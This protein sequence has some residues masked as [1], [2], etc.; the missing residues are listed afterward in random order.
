MTWFRYLN[1]L[2]FFFIAVF[3]IAYVLYVWRIYRIAKVLNTSFKRIIAKLLLRLV[4]G[5][6]I[7]IALLGP[8]F[9]EVQKEI[10]TVGKDIYIAVDLSQSMDA[11]DLSPSRLEKVK[12]ELKNLVQALSA[13]RIG[14][15]IFSSE[16]FMQCPLTFDQSALSIFI[17]TMNTNLVPSTGT[18]YSAVLKMVLQKFTDEDNDDTNK[19]NSRVLLLI[20]D[21]E[22]FGEESDSYVKDLESANIKVFT[23]GVGTKEGGKIP[24]RKSYKRDASG[25]EVITTLNDEKLKEIAT[26]VNGKYFELSNVRNDMKALLNQIRQIKGEV[27]DVKKVDVA[28]NKYNY[29]LLLALVLVVLDIL[30]TIKVLKI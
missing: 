15:V 29:F 11:T 17:E 20:S 6:L 30:V 14:I 25:R 10:K 28:Q 4:Y 26:A 5:T 23:L 27:R 13:D 12:Y 22:D 18:D 19:N 2:D 9:G 7:L 21:G 1:S 3:I 24:F 8:S 16:A